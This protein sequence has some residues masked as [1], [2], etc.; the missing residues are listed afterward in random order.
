MLFKTCLIY[1]ERFIQHSKAVL[2]KKL[3][4]TTT[5]VANNNKNFPGGGRGGGQRAHLQPLHSE[6]K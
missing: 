6:F 2:R 5:P 4:M 3:V 1:L